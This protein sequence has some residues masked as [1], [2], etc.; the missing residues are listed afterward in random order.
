MLCGSS[1]SKPRTLL[2]PV[3][4][5]LVTAPADVTLLML[6]PFP[7]ELKSEEKDYYQKYLLQ[8]RSER[9]AEDL[10]DVQGMLMYKG[11]GA[12]MLF[13][14]VIETTVPD[15]RDALRRLERIQAAAK[16]EPARKGWELQGKRLETLICLLQSADHM[17]AY[18]A[19]LD[20]VRALGL[21]PEKN[22]PL[23]VQSDWAR[24]DLME[25]ARKEI[26]TAVRL[27]ELMESTP[28]P[29]LDTAPTPAEE[30]IMR[31]GPDLPAQLQ[32]KIDTM[33]AHWRDYDRIFTAPNP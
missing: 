15:V 9:Q 5:L 12:K 10:V 19:Q 30:T 17:V 27:K 29:L 3:T 28:E 16:D 21:K 26:D 4:K 13:Q 23:G 32:R 1:S 31:L 2:S 25:T 18:Q 24:T 6:A 33:N 20:R 22:P 8:A 14:R 11:W 7:E